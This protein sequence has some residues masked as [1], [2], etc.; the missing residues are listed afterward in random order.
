MS[1]IIYCYLV[2]IIWLLFF[3]YAT[4]SLIGEEGLFSPATFNA[5]ILTLVGL[6]P[7]YCGWR[8]SAS[9]KQM[10]KIS[11]LLNKYQS[12][13]GEKIETFANELGLTQEK[14]VNLIQN[15]IHYKF[16]HRIY[17]DFIQQKV[18]Y[19]ESADVDG[20]QGV[21]F[22]NLKC[23]ACGATNTAVKGSQFQCEYCGQENIASGKAESLIVNEK[24]IETE[25]GKTID[26]NYM[27]G[28]A[29]FFIALIVLIWYGVI[30][31]AVMLL[32]EDD[33]GVGASLMG[34]GFAL[35]LGVSLAAISYAC[36]QF[37]YEKFNIKYAR[38]LIAKYLSAV[39][40]TR[41]PE[42]TTIGEI[43][44][45]LHEEN[46]KAEK[47]IKF[48]IKRGYLPGVTI[49]GE[50]PKVH[51]LDDDTNFDRFVPVQC[52]NCNGEFVATYGKANRCPYCENG[53]EIEKK[54]S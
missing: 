1:R 51:Y 28:C 44:K 15:A 53:V 39:I 30:K 13:Q 35:L 41:K 24:N 47:D 38:P 4:V 32:T 17:I 9:I 49:K 25:Y 3:G 54:N 18:I 43:A 50:P 29:P 8:M 21:S 36:V 46:T 48:L 19:I 45:I 52:D 42:G 16:V 26:E 7:L 40:A 6:L 23:E 31:F 33:S 27:I 12:V 2:G 22:V 20:K 34:W 11:D 5:M 10:E 14:A 37:I